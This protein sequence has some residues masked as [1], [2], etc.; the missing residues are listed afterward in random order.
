MNAPRPRAEQGRLPEQ[1]CLPWDGGFAFPCAGTIH[2]VGLFADAPRQNVVTRQLER[3]P[4][5]PWYPLNH[6]PSIGHRTPMYEARRMKKGSKRTRR[7][8]SIP[9]LRRAL[10]PVQDHKHAA[11][12]APRGGGEARP[13]R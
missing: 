4:I 8:Q 2:V 1:S 11:P 3:Q 9:V 10:M 5:A 13:A 12:H 7:F 6:R